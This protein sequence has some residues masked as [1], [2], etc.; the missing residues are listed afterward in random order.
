MGIKDDKKRKIAYNNLAVIYANEDNFT[1][2]DEFFNE[3]LKIDPG[4]KDAKLNL[5]LVYDKTKSPQKAMAYWVKVLNLD[6]LKSK[7]FMKYAGID[8]N[9][10]KDCESELC[11]KV[12]LN[13]QGV[14]AAQKGDLVKA[15]ELFNSALEIDPN[16]EIAKLNLG[17]VYD[18]EGVNPDNLDY[19]M[20]VFDV[21]VEV[22]KPKEFI[23]DK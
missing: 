14:D 10:L 12:I 9:F 5:G 17:L 8:D 13:N 18:I 4:Y 16:C 21:S 2:A 20:R 15:K 1:K 11:K 3:A 22:I 6:K 23:I 19:W 7:E